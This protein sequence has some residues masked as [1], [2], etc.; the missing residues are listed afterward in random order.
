MKTKLILIFAVGI[1]LVGVF[2]VVFN[3]KDPGLPPGFRL[4]CSIGGKKHTLWMPNGYIS[5]NAWSSE[6]AAKRYA[7]KWEKYNKKVH[8]RASDAFEWEDCGQTAT[9]HPK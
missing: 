2:Y 4:L 6:I 8:K 9:S 1:F 5:P 3:P 7:W